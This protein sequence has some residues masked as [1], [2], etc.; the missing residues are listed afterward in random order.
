MKSRRAAIASLAFCLSLWL[1]T[2]VT[3]RWT[4]EYCRHSEDGPTFAAFGIPFPYERFGGASSLQYIFAPHALLLNML[5]LGIIFALML[6]FGL[7]KHP[8]PSFRWLALIAIALGVMRIFFLLVLFYNQMLIPVKNIQD[9]GE[10]LEPTG[11]VFG[12]ADNRC[13]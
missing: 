6:Y 3:I 9:D 12:F 8:Q 11:I 1:H 5:I 2:C 10:R 13:N 4:S 7:P